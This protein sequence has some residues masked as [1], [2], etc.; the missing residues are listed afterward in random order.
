MGISIKQSDFIRQEIMKIQKLLILIFIFCLF[1]CTSQ[2]EPESFQEGDLYKERMN[3]KEIKHCKKNWGEV[4]RAGRMGLPHCVITYPDAGKACKDSSEC[5]ARCLLV[6]LDEPA[7]AQVMGKCQQNSLRF[8][9]Y[10]VVKNGVAGP[11]ICVD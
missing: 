11:V 1:A 2:Q 9:C 4:Q 10:A 7:G 6:N 5:T 3:S 8:G